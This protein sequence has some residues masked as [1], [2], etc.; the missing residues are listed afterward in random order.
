[1]IEE[2]AKAEHLLEETNSLGY[3]N[4]KLTKVC[5]KLSKKITAD[6]LFL[7]RCQ[8]DAPTALADSTLCSVSSSNIPYLSGILQV[9]KQS[10]DV[11]EVIYYIRKYG[12]VV[13]VVCNG[14][15][16]WKKVI[17]RNPQSLHLIWA[18]QGQYGSKDIVKKAERY[19]VCA[20]QRSEFSPPNIVYVFCNGVTHEMAETLESMGIEV[21]GERVDV[22]RE[23]EERLTAVYADSDDSDDE[24]S[25]TICT[26]PG[27][28]YST[29]SAEPNCADLE[30]SSLS[31]HETEDSTCSLIKDIQNLSRDQKIFM[32]ITTM[33][34]YVS[35]LCNG[36]CD[37]QFAE[38]VLTKQAAEERQLPALD[39]ILPHMTNKK[40]VTCQSALDDYWGIVNIMAGPREKARAKSLCDQMVVVP[41]CISSRFSSLV[42][43]GQ[44]RE[45]SKVIFGAADMLHCM[46]LTSN[47]GFIRAAAAQNIHIAAIVHQPRALS[48]EKTIC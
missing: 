4:S 12:I 47:E 6:I 25:E 46:I 43:S 5:S 34:V 38:S 19:L 8:A 36:G 15:R 48:E 45:R 32:D 11:S 10:D 24:A 39:V 37:K 14:G 13:D 29:L 41:D 16:T 26:V 22:S 42:V 33:L 28:G 27:I 44:I 31:K 1:M 35:D 23:V 7:Q 18:G 30:A 21:I 40:L 3:N 20:K 9:V 17:A 2:L